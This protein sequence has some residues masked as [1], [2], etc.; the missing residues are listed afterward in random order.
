MSNEN[1]VDN[2]RMQAQCHAQE[3]RTANS[4]INEIYQVVTEAKGEPGSWNGASPVRDK[5]A[6]LKAENDRLREAL[7]KIDAIRNSIIGYQNVGWSEHIYPLVAALNEA[8]FEGEEYKTARAKVEA[9][10]E[11]TN[12]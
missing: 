10:L 8:G 6:V 3:A 1:L 12:D 4:T 9:A 11:K 5:L 7:T 2:L